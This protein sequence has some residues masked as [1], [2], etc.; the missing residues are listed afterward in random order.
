MA[1]P[2]VYRVFVSKD[3]MK[4]NAAHFIAFKGFRE[5]LHGHNYRMSVTITG[6][7]IGHDGY[8]MDFG[9]IKK[10]A[11]EVCRELNEH[12]I[13]PSKSDVLKIDVTDE[14]VTLVTEDNKTFSFPREDCSLL[15]IVHSS[16]EELARYLMDVLLE[17]FTMTQMKA[18]HATKIEVSIAEAENQLA[19]VTRS[20]D[21]SELSP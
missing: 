11:R 16:A 1:V 20:L 5:R 3:Y 17:R 10:I 13:V 6:D 4:F 15:P 7:R 8:L 14:T 19:S 21:Y 9:D 12:F 18:R 2:D